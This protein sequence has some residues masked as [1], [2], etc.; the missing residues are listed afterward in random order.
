MSL[1]YNMFLK[2]TKGLLSS[3]LHTVNNKQELVV[4]FLD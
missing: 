3:L 4:Y 1:L 2:N